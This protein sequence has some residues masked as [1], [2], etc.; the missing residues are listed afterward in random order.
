MK[1]DLPWLSYTLYSIYCTL[2]AFSRS[3]LNHA[4]AASTFFLYDRNLWEQT[5]PCC[6]KDT[7]CQNEST[8]VHFSP[9]ATI[10]F[11][12]MGLDI[13]SGTLHG[14]R[15]DSYPGKVRWYI[16]PSYFNVVQNSN[17][18]HLFSIRWHPQLDL[19]GKFQWQLVSLTVVLLYVNSC[20]LLTLTHTPPHILLAAV[21]FI[22]LHRTCEIIHRGR[23]PS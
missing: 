12:G 8:G 16:Q 1:P 13:I 21:F 10:Y 2:F 23:N 3:I 19:W 20:F 9:S 17:A 22:R 6:F 18:C 14:F 4:R 15:F 7:A 11:D 5:D